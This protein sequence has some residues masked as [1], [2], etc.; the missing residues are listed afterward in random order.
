MDS[1][2]QFFSKAYE[3]TSTKR[4]NN[5]AAETSTVTG[6]STEDHSASPRTSGMLCDTSHPVP[7]TAKDTSDS[8]T[9]FA[10]PELPE[11]DPQAA[12]NA[13]P[14]TESSTAQPETGVE[15]GKTHSNKPANT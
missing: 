11:S 15:Q 5:S 3:Y 9:D 4:F 14:I 10:I 2:Y 8:A 6:P 7:S 13:S 1:A 12:M